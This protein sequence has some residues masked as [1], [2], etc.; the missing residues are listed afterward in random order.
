VTEI[1][2]PKLV[3]VLPTPNKPKKKRNNKNIKKNSAKPAETAA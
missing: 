3:K 1:I 2:A